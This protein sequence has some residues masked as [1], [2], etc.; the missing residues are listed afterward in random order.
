VALKRPPERTE[1]G[2]SGKGGID[3][4][5]VSGD[6]ELSDREDIMGVEGC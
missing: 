2:S 3:I 5:R 4:C 1:F 6:E